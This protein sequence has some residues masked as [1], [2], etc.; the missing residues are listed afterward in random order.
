MD[1][2]A[3]IRNAP[4]VILDEPTVGLDNH[5]ERLVTDALDRLTQTS[6]TFLI[7]LTLTKIFHS[8]SS[9]SSSN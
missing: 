2:R 8:S 9:R 3:A 6:T 1:N 7:F 5:S 4:I